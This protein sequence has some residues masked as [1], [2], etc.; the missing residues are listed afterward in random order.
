MSAATREEVARFCRGIPEREE[1][2]DR[3]HRY[4]RSG[5]VR[6]EWCFIATTPDGRVLA[7]H[8]WWASPGSSRPTGLDLI[9]VEDHHS[10][11]VL[12]RLARDQL[13]VNEAVCELTVPLEPEAGRAIDT[14][15]EWGSVLT[16][17][18]FAFDVARVRVEWRP[19]PSSIASCSAR[20]T[21]W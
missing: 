13:E 6:P 9:G 10:A 15:G 17:S 3:L 16:A 1:V 21:T 14:R 20:S 12:V 8:W 7:R 5:S 11:A 2:E 19:H 4:L 18:S